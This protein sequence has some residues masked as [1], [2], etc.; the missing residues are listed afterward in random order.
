[1]LFFGLNGELSNS[2]LPVMSSKWNTLVTFPNPKSK[3]VPNPL[4]PPWKYI[5]ISLNHSYS[6]C[7]QK[8]FNL[9]AHLK[10]NPTISH[11][12]SSRISQFQSGSGSVSDNPTI[13]HSTSIFCCFFTIQVPEASR[14]IY[15]NCALQFLP[16]WLHRQLLFRL[17]S[18]GSDLRRVGKP[19][20]LRHR[21]SFAPAS[22]CY[23]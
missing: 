10:L 12:F 21:C 7:T 6:F 1:M 4:I 5:F 14:S 2:P 23:W 19:Y 18:T 8:S 3:K 22:Y 11:G 13:L 9:Y 17:H 16:I 20:R 15:A